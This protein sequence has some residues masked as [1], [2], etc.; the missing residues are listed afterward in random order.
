[1]SGHSGSKF[2]GPPG[3]VAIVGVGLIGGSLG[4]ALRRTWPHCRILGV[5]RP[6]V[7]ARARA[8]GAIDAAA[9][10][11]AAARSELVVLAAPVLAIIRLL[12]KLGACLGPTTVV[13]DAGSTKQAVMQAAR[14]RLPRD[15]FI[16][17]HPLAGRELGGIEAADGGLFRGAGW[18]LVA[19]RGSAPAL[20][21]VRTLVRAC[22]ARP[23]LC[24][25]AQHDRAL[26]RVSQ[27]PQLAASALMAQAAAPAALAFA[28]SGLRDTTRLAA[29]PY[30]IWAD[31]L[32]TNRR[33]LERVVRGLSQDLRRMVR[34]P[35]HARRVFQTAQRGRR[36][37][38]DARRGAARG[39]NRMR[40]RP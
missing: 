13:T 26:A 40:R 11:P 25:A 9:T 37:L 38:L 3:S 23:L 21:R 20:A 32:A 1:M 30:S 29:S 15:R 31:I 33:E 12:D 22:G 7:L 18:A 8:R 34:S 14:R 2:N 39:S 35:A 6:R 19:P 27:L 16:G 28:G 17:G 36:R 10:L 24:T 5:D 4:L